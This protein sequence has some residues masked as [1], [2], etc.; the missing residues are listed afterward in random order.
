MRFRVN[1]WR[2]R[3]TGSGKNDAYRFQKEGE[4]LHVGKRKKKVGTEPIFI[5]SVPKKDHRRL[6]TLFWTE[7][8][9]LE[10]TK[11]RLHVKI[12]PSRSIFFRWCK[13]VL[14]TRLIV[15]F[16]VRSSITIF[17]V[18]LKRQKTHVY[19]WTSKSNGLVLLKWLFYHTNYW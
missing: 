5:R 1:S 7:R 13:R 11:Y 18:T 14:R 2:R 12:Y 19:R 15:D 3:T 4:R 17:S 8:V 10:R 9:K 6:W 16:A